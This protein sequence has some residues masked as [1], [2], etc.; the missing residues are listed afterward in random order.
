[1]GEKSGPASL[2]GDIYNSDR[3][4]GMLLHSAT[5]LYYCYDIPTTLHQ[6]YAG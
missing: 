2:K 4:G 6:I 3:A 1:M 5:A